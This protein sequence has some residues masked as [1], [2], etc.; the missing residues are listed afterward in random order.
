MKPCHEVELKIVQAFK[1]CDVQLEFH[2]WQGEYMTVPPLGFIND[3]H[4]FR[5]VIS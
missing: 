4:P 1:G 3:T 2:E 5:V